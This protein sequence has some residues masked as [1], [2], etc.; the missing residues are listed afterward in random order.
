MPSGKGKRRACCQQPPPLW[1]KNRAPF[2][3]QVP[4]TL[5]HLVVQ[6]GRLD[7]S[8]KLGERRR[9]PTVAFQVHK[10]QAGTREFEQVDAHRGAVISLRWSFDGCILRTTSQFSRNV[11]H[12]ALTWA[13]S[14]S[15][16]ATAGED[17]IVKV[18]VFVAS[19]LRVAV[20]FGLEVWSRSGMLRSA[21][22]QQSGSEDTMIDT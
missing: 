1:L 16:I 7:W 4:R 17:G 5:L 20:G 8:A 18:H 12:E 21:L 6:T 15:A 3:G 9:R 11:G 13:C 14:G 10:S 22:A 19:C 2:L